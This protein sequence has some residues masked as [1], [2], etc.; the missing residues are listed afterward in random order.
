MKNVL[1]TSANAFKASVPA[2]NF[3]DL[4]GKTHP[5]FTPAIIRGAIPCIKSGDIVSDI[6]KYL[7][8]ARNV[9]FWAIEMGTNDAWGGTNANVTTFKNNMKHI[10][11]S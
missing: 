9:K 11:D 5:S 2:E 4:V 7:D 3:A 6:S 8:M 10:I 1:M